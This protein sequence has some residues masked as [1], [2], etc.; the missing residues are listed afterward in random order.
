MILASHGEEGKREVYANYVVNDFGNVIADGHTPGSS[1]FLKEGVVLSHVQNFD[2]RQ[3]ETMSELASHIT[4][5]VVD[6]LAG[7]IMDSY[8]YSNGD[9]EFAIDKNAF[10]EFMDAFETEHKDEILSLFQDMVSVDQSFEPHVN[11]LFDG[12]MYIADVRKNETA[13]PIVV[14]LKVTRRVA[15]LIDGLKNMHALIQAMPDNHELKTQYGKI[16][17]K[18]ISVLQYRNLVRPMPKYNPNARGSLS[19]IYN[20]DDTDKQEIDGVVVRVEDFKSVHEIEAA[21]KEYKAEG[22]KV[23]FVGKS[24]AIEHEHALALSHAT[25]LERSGS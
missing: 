4:E 2:S 23:I 6:I 17:M 15:D 13:E 21:I 24:P 1:I 16:L 20:P 9:I 5:G 7:S 14:Y 19:S 12:L 3:R 25:L 10:I 8:E 11:K 22:L 18:L